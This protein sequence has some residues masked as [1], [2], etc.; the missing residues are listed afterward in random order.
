VQ[1][2]QRH[3]EDALARGATPVVG[4][5]DSLRGGAWVDPVVLTDVPEDA[6]AITEETFG[7]TLPIQRVRDVDEAVALTNRS[8]YGLGSTVF[9][10][11]GAMDIARRI[12]AGGTSIN[13]VTIFG[14]MSSIPFG[15]R[16]ESGFGRIH[17]DDGLREFSMP[18]GITRLRFPLPVDFTSFDRPAWALPVATKVL[19]LRYRRARKG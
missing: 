8:R 2:I 3:V 15:G 19:Q 18:K 6:P 4:G 13:A 11:K 10:A 7:P 17:G 12:R 1:V 16:G 14:A 9:A 5:A